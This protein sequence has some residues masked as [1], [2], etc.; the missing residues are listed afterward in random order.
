ME[1]TLRVHVETTGQRVT[2]WDKKAAQ[3]STAC[4]MMTKFAA[5]IVLNIG[6]QRQR[7][8]PL[9]TVQQPYLLALGISATYF[10]VPQR[11]YGEEEGTCG[12]Q[13]TQGSQRRT[14]PT[15][16]ERP[17]WW[18]RNTACRRL[19]LAGWSGSTSKASR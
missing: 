5:V 8:Q 2:G 16:R 3:Q 10:T 11:G 1:R 4:M 12:R 6:S 13:K 19:P 17:W 14:G 9:S 7:A 15:G 18:E